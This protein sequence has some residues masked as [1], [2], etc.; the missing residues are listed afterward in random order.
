V[1][2]RFLHVLIAFALISVTQLL[3]WEVLPVT[4][5][6]ASVSSPEKSDALFSDSDGSFRLESFSLASDMKSPTQMDPVM[7]LLFGSGLVGLAGLGRNKV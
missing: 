1:K 3:Q 7:L 6:Y 5:G 2:N 4:G